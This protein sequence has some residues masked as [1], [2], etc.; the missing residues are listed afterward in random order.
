M[1]RPKIPSRR[2]RFR[3]LT[4]V[5]RNWQLRADSI[6]VSHTALCAAFREFRSEFL[7]SDDTLRSSHAAHPLTLFV[8]C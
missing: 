8:V 1:S 2:G 3:G 5:K 7:L 4:N 6:S